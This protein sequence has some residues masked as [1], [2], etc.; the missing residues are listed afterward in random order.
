MPREKL[1]KKGAESLTDIE[2]LQAV[3]G[4]G[5]KNN[6]FRQ[7]AKNLNATIERVGAF[8]SGVDK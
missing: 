8:I 6:D 7:I 5:G 2:L 4:S 1:N 3:I